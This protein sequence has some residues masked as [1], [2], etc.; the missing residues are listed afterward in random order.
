MRDSSLHDPAVCDAEHSPD[1]ALVAIDTPFSSGPNDLDQS[2]SDLLGI[3]A[4]QMVHWSSGSKLSRSVHY[5]NRK[6]SGTFARTIT[7]PHCGGPELCW[8]ASPKC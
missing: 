1:V 5:D 2:W 4:R 3:S 7:G 6:S 8:R